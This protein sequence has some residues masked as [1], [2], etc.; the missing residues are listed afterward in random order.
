MVAGRFAEGT[1][2]RRPGDGRGDGE[3]RAGDDWL[4]RRST[5]AM[6]LIAGDGVSS[7]STRRS[8]T[9]SCAHRVEMFGEA[10]RPDC[11]V[12]GVDGGMNHQRRH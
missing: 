5:V 1:A 9:W 11:L 10:R 6:T 7:S 12:T 4:R 3:R 8:P 2:P